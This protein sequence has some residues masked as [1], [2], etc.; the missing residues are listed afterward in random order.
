M[1][2]DKQAYEDEYRHIADEEWGVSCG[3]DKPQAWWPSREAADQCA[4]RMSM[5]NGYPRPIVIVPRYIA[6]PASNTTEA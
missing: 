5:Y 3:G 6:E 4:K 2:I 1:T